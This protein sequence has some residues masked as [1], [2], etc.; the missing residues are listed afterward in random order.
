MIHKIEQNWLIEAL[1][2]ID[3]LNVYRRE[4][5]LCGFSTRNKSPNTKGIARSIIVTELYIDQQ[6]LN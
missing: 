4:M 5:R 1:L 6:N 2:T 3:I